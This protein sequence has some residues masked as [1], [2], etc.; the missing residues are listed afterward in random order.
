MSATTLP[1]TFTTQWLNNVF[2]LGKNS[3]VRTECRK[4][5]TFPASIFGKR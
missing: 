3:E 1:L 4:V 2:L 5:T